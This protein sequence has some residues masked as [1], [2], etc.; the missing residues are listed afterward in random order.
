MIS[1]DW[2]ASSGVPV[3]TPS[4][5]AASAPVS[6]RH[7]TGSLRLD[8]RPLIMGILNV[9]PDSFS[10]GGRY[11]DPDRAVAHGLAMAEDGA[12]ILDVG[13][14]S[15]RPG[16]EETDAAE[17][18][19]RVIPVVQALRKR[20][21]TPI[22]VD[23]RKAEVARQAI[24]AGA[25]I[26]NDV[27]ACAHDPAM[28]DVVVKYGVGLVLMHMR[29]D[30]RTMQDAPE[31]SD[32]VRETTNELLERANGLLAKG[33]ERERLALDPGIG[34]G[35]TLDHNLDL[36]ARL[37]ALVATGY[38]VAAGVSRKSWIGAITGRATGERLA[39][40]LAAAVHCFAQGARVLRVHDVRE[41]RD[42]IAVAV[43]LKRTSHGLA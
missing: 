16:A 32:V 9:T 26:V 6:W 30:P 10:D 33:V 42:A 17:E 27:S 28:A 19:R 22:S 8:E 34:F 29:G 41:T 11:S 39:G 14:E 40:S 36:L 23:T 31:Y 38:P 35:K 18:L 15:T 20:T 37:S 21:E 24:E 1:H 4:E 25:V 2:K 5:L 12:D 3:A 7:R 13:G 43:A